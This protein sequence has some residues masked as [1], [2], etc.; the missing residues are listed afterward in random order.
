MA[1]SFTSLPGGGALL[2]YGLAV[3]HPRCD[4]GSHV[5]PATEE[6]WRNQLGPPPQGGSYFPTCFSSPSSLQGNEWFC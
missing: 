3:P 4:L 2:S 1:E 5:M 6:T